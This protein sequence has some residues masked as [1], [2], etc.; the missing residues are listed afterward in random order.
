MSEDT[1]PLVALLAAPETAPSVLYGLYDVLWSAGA[2]FHEITTG[3]AGSAL[4]D[5]RVVAGAAEPFRC[6]GNVMVEPHEAIDDLDHVDVAVICDIYTPIDVPPCDRYPREV[7]WIRKVHG[8]GAIVASV[9]SGSLI[10]A[11][12]GLLDGLEATGHWAYRQLSR[13]HFPK[14]KW[15]E[16]PVICLA[17]EEKRIVTAGGV[18]SWQDLALYLIAQLCGPEHA[19][20]TAKVHLLGDHGD[21]QLPFAA[22]TQRIQRTDAV[23]GECQ[24]WIADNYTCSNPVARMADRTGLQPRTFARRFRAA[25]GY[26]PME[27]IQALRIEEAKQLL[28]RERLSIDEIGAEVGYEDPTFFR[29]LF[30]RKAGLTPTA[31]RRK[32]ASIVPS[33]VHEGADTRV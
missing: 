6:A 18:T 13:E 23:I 2:V 20:Q 29:R 33:K 3:E 5:V 17:G 21:G 16:D 15:R 11:E 12:T 10:L 27:Y 22:M 14:V 8:N 30:K 7:D 9:C 32:F 28:E 4:I 19:I 26:Q 1:R 24:V 31:Y 25:T